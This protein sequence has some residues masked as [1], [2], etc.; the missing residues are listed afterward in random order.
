VIEKG[1]VFEGRSRMDELQSSNV[2]PIYAT[3][4]DDK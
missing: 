2:V 3:G 1:V 4:S